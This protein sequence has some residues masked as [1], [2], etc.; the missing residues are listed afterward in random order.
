[1]RPITVEIAPVYRPARLWVPET[2]PWHSEQ[3]FRERLSRA[4]ALPFEAVDAGNRSVALS[5]RGARHP[6]DAPAKPR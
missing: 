4:P 1:M 6:C 5:D 2:R 3:A